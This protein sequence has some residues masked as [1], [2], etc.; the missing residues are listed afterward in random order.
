MT[1][2]EV[3]QQLT[4]LCQA[5]KFDEAMNTLYA[6]NITSLEAMEMPGGAPRETKGL[7]N[8]QKK[9]LWWNENH[10]IHSATTTGTY[11]SLEKFSV[12]FAFD[13]THKPTGQR[14]QMSEVAVYTV[15][16]GKITHEEFLYK[17]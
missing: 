16:N 12:L 6:D 15:E 13:V 11:A 4:S 3:A 10:T 17:M 8:V 14:R 9:A 5:G 1:T 7:P 2:A